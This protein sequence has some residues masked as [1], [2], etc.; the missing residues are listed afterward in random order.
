MHST[1]K[2]GKYYIAFVLTGVRVSG[3]EIQPWL[4][5]QCEAPLDLSNQALDLKDYPGFDYHLLLIFLKFPFWFLR[6]WLCGLD[7]VGGG[8]G[9][10]EIWLCLLFLGA[11][12]IYVVI[13]IEVSPI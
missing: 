10:N 5:C 13:E 7:W 11:C 1:D 3:R 12:L 2:R 6:H 8:C 9:C 4:L